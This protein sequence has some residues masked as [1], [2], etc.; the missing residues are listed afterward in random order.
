MVAKVFQNLYIILFLCKH[1]FTF[2]QIFSKSKTDQYSK[3]TRMH[4]WWKQHKQQNKSASFV[5]IVHKNMKLRKVPTVSKVEEILED[6]LDSIL[7][8][9]PSVKIQIMGR[10]DCFRCKGKTLLGIVIKLLQN[11]TFWFQKFVDNV[12]QCFC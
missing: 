6:C 5:G 9:S 8:P 2:F 4:G 12:K 10:K 7:S 1:D 3:Q 11:K